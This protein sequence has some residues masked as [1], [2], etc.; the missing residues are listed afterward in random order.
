[1]KVMKASFFRTQLRKPLRP[2]TDLFCSTTRSRS[3]NTSIL[4]GIRLAGNRSRGSQPAR[5]QSAPSDPA[6]MF[7]PA[8]S[9]S[10]DQCW[11]Y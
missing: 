3:T 5:D 2:E 1:M 9:V 7:H 11:F 4:L 6:E 10:S 8:G